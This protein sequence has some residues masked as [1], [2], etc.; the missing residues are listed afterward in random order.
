MSRNRR[1]LRKPAE[2]R[3]I[4][5]VARVEII[6]TLQLHG[7]STVAEIGERL[8]RAADSLYHHLR[9]LV[10]SGLVGREAE[11]A[12]SGRRAAVYELSSIGFVAE[13]APSAKRS[14]REAFGAASSAVLRT[15]ARDVERE[16]HAPDAR[17]SGPARNL[18]VQRRKVQLTPS[19]LRELNR[20]VDAIH[21]LLDDNAKQ[22][23]G[24]RFT[25]T[26]V[27]VRPAD[28]S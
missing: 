28:R 19:A 15:V 23:N 26:T 14:F 7:P 12:G 27:L 9:I 21:R 6:E 16:V 8:G 25:F 17:S 11:R 2:L 4:S 10:S 5:H 20:H 1:L 3:A 24:A 22:P 13:L 18:E